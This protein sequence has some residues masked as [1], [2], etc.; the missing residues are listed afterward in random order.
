MSKRTYQLCP[1]SVWLKQMKIRSKYDLIEVP[2]LYQTVEQLHRCHLF[3]ELTTNNVKW[4]NLWTFR[5]TIILE[6]CCGTH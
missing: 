4:W 6:D 3:V 1:P 5:I 2:W